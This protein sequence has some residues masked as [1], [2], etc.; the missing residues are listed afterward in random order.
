MPFPMTDLDSLLADLPPIDHVP[1]DV[2]PQLVFDDVSGLLPPDDPN[3]VSVGIEWFAEVSRCNQYRGLLSSCM[4]IIE[5]SVDNDLVDAA[6]VS[7][8]LGD[9]Q[10]AAL[11]SLL[12]VFTPLDHRN[13]LGLAADVFNRNEDRCVSECCLPDTNWPV[14]GSQLGLELNHL[15]ESFL[16]DLW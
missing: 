9:A 16:Q 5:D 7:G 12:P 1:A 10:E 6:A 3:V 14:S 4:T 15:S 2:L 13:R 8:A 11:D